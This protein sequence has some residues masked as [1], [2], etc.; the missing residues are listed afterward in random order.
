MDEEMSQMDKFFN[1]F[2]GI[3]GPEPKSSSRAPP[4]P[5]DKQNITNDDFV[6]NFGFFGSMNPRM[7]SLNPHSNSQNQNSQFRSFSNS[8][9]QSSTSY[10]DPKRPEVMITK[11]VV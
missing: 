8:Y 7:G 4:S 5:Y 6:R 1:E 11:T 10:R 2:F 3:D 9:S